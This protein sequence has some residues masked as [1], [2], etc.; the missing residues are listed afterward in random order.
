M[1]QSGCVKEEI[2]NYKRIIENIFD[3]IRKSEID[4]ESKQKIL[5]FRNELVINGYSKARII[6]YLDTLERIGKL[7]SKLFTQVKKEDIIEFVR[8]IEESDYSPWTKQDYFTILRIFFRWLR[9]QRII[10]KR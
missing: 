2:Y 10:Q 3:R 7:L 5:E 6:K 4:E 1:G 8:K 9:K